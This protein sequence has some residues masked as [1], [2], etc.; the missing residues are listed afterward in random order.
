M[1][2]NVLVTLDSN[3]IYPLKVMLKSL[4]IN[5]NEDKF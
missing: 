4:F 3:Y 1:L 2:M 5:N